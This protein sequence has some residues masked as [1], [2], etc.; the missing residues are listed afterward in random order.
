MQS[1]NPPQFM[2]P[3]GP[4]PSSKQSATCTYP[5]P[6]EFSLRPLPY[7]LK[8]HYNSDGSKIF[9]VL[10]FLQTYRPKLCTDL[11]VHTCHTPRP[12]HYPR[13]DHPNNIW[14]TAHTTQLLV[15]L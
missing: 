10:Y 3:E 4:L 2:E 1:R 7:S 5:E 8:I 6:G 14:W 12:L 11:L 15:T 13:L 9:Q